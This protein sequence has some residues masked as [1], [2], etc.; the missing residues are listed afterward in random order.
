[1]F[2]G[3]LFVIILSNAVQFRNAV[4]ENKGWHEMNYLSVTFALDYLFS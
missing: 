4:K 3:R 1:M 2:K